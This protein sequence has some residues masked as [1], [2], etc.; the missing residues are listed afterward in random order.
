MKSRLLLIV[1]LMAG[2]CLVGCQKEPIES[3][4]NAVIIKPANTSQVNKS[5]L[6]KKGTI[7]Y[8][9]GTVFM[10]GNISDPRIGSSYECYF[11]R[12]KLTT[13]PEDYESLIVSIHGFRHYGVDYT[14]PGQEVDLITISGIEE[15][16]G[17]GKYL[18]IPLSQGIYEGGNEMIKDVQ[19]ISLK[20]STSDTHG[21]LNK[22]ADINIVIYSTAGDTITIRFANDITRRIGF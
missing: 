14:F 8:P 17:L 16:L 5:L 12:D 22:D 6:T 7:E 9:I 18:I 2:C 4:E 15:S 13:E 11:Y 1:S 19:I 10:G 20:G 21:T 3:N